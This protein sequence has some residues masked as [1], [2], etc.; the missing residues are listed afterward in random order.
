MTNTLIAQKLA[1]IP[2]EYLDEVATYLDFLSYRIAQMQTPQHKIQRSP[3]ILKEDIYM[4]DDF[5]APLDDF[6]EYM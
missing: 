1:A 5:D 2:E 6:K 4:S 3:G